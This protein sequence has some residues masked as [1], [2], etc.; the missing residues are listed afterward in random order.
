MYSEILSNIHT[1]TDVQMLREEV[2]RL[3]VSFYKTKDGTFEEVLEKNVRGWV[4]SELKNLF[5]AEGAER[6][7]VLKSLMEELNGLT[8]LKLTL[9][10]EP[11]QSAIGKIYDWLKQN[12][13]ENVVLDIGHNPTILAGAIVDFR[14]KYGDFS[15]RKRLVKEFEDK[16]Q[17]IMKL[18]A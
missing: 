3:T 1:T 4:S 12:V 7:E 10:F 15:L 11:S 13:G 6:P 16:K 18:V 14:G 2:E 9:G 5:A 8:P 17:E